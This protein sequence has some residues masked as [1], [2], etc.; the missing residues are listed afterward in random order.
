[1]NYFIDTCV[2]RDFYENRKSLSGKPLGSYAASCFTTLFKKKA[3]IL[4]SETLIMELSKDYGLPE[5]QRMLGL[6][7]IRAIPITKQEFVEA[8]QLSREKDIPFAD[9]LNAVQARNHHAILV[10]RDHHFFNEL[11]E[12]TPAVRPEDVS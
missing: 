7:K 9:C 3:C 2:W 5:I 4:I 11:K 1:M 8:R 6:I 10:T 12:I